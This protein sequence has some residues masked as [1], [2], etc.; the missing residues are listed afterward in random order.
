MARDCPIGAEVFCCCC[1]CCVHEFSPNLGEGV[2]VFV[3]VCAFFG[4]FLSIGV[5]V[6]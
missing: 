5:C 3:C 6:E 2:C 4:H 1:C